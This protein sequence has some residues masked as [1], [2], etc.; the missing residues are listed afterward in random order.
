MKMMAP[1]GSAKLPRKARAAMEKAME[2]TLATALA[3]RRQSLASEALYQSKM[4]FAVGDFQR[5]YDRITMYFPD[6]DF[7]GANLVA[8][9]TSDTFFFELELMFA[10]AA[11]ETGRLEE[12]KRHYLSVVQ[13]PKI[14]SSGRLLVIALHDLGRI[15]AK[16]GDAQQAISFLAFSITALEA[17]RATINSEV[18]KMGFAGDNQAVYGDI[19][20]LLF[21]QGQYGQA[22]EYVE[23]AKS[24]ALVD[25]L[26]G[27]QSFG[28]RKVKASQL[29]SQLT[30]SQLSLEV[31][32]RGEYEGA[33]RGIVVLKDE[34][35]TLDPQLASLVTVSS[36]DTAELSELLGEDETL[37]EYYL[38]AGQLYIFVLSR[39][40]VSGV[41]VDAENL[42][43]D[44]EAFREAIQNSNSTN[45]AELAVR[46]HRQLF[47]PLAAG[48]QTRSVVIVPHGPLHYLPFGALLGDEGYLIKRYDLRILPSA[49]VMKFLAAGGKRD[50]SLLSLGNPDLGNTELDLPGAQTEVEAI[51]AMVPGAMTLLRT[52]ASETRF[53]QLARQYSRVHFAVHGIFEPDAPLTSGLLLSKDGK[54]D[55][56]LTA[57]ELFGLDMAADLVTL[58]ACET[59][60]GNVSQGDDVVGLTRGFLYAGASS[61]V[62]SL[63]KVDDD[64]TAFLMT[65]FY[66]NL[67]GS[68]KTQALRQAQVATL[69]AF[70]HPFYW[71][72]FQL[73]GS[74]I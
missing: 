4:L 36:A 51:A 29:I 62:S 34:L 17:Q 37:V 30:A 52:D 56:L 46:L 32:P 63:W 15:A 70:P 27:Q 18:S 10:K 64:A 53:K 22:L 42:G 39:R 47:L 65:R 72:A 50:G 1:A 31:V 54:N 16:E 38:N 74:G 13:N 60:L 21:A 9:I 6:R 41:K 7:G 23:R 26:A 2:G 73:T 11:F 67:Q 20:S 43:E 5:A 14:Q 49:T 44:I 24:R 33:V 19:V 61:I 58:S 28:K 45:H 40:G 71:A 3:A 48:I 12:A 57:S 25:M 8:D 66:R 68:N 59:G 35:Q 55:G 69:N